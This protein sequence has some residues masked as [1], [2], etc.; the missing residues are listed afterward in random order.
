GRGGPGT[1]RLTRRG[2]VIDYVVP[3]PPGDSLVAKLEAYRQRADG[4]RPSAYVV[5]R[6]DNRHGQDCIEGPHELYVVT[7]G[8]REHPVEPAYLFLQEWVAEY[9][10]AHGVG[11][12]E[13]GARLQ[14]ELSRAGRA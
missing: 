8:H 7:K 12:D 9:E 14:D 3:A 10:G 1:Y 4:A 11:R 2:A 6:V 13:E 5:G